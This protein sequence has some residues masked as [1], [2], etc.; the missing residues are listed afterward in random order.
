MI[1]TTWLYRT[2]P[3]MPHGEVAGIFFGVAPLDTEADE[4]SNNMIA[5]IAHVNLRNITVPFLR[6]SI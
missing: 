5:A 6:Y 3:P 1:Q 2:V 4:A